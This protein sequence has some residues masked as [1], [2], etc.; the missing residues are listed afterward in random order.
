MLLIPLY[1]RKPLDTEYKGCLGE[2]RYGRGITSPVVADT[3]VFPFIPRDAK[4]SF[5]ES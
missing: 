5:R 2:N 3:T 4:R 1:V